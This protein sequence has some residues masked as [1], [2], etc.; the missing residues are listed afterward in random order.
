MA[1]TGVIEQP[2]ALETRSEV[3]KLVSAAVAVRRGASDQVEIGRTASSDT[4]AGRETQGVGGQ[5]VEHAHSQLTRAERL[6]TRIDGKLSSHGHSDTTLLGGAMAETYAGAMLVLAGMSDDLVAGGGLRLSASADLHLAGLIGGEERIGTAIADGALLEAYG[7]HFEREYG[8]GHHVAGFAR[9]SGTIHT[10]VATGFRP[11]FKVM[12]GVRNLTPGTG[13]SGT[14]DANGGTAQMPTPVPPPAGGASPSAGLLGDTPDVARAADA[15]AE[16]LTNVQAI[17]NVGDLATDGARGADTADQLGEARHMTLADIDTALAHQRARA[18]LPDEAGM[19][20]MLDFLRRLGDGE[21]GDEAVRN[22]GEVMARE[23]KDTTSP[24]YDLL[25]SSGLDFDALTLQDTR[26][27]L[28]NEAALARDSGDLARAAELQGILNGFDATV[29]QSTVDFLERFP[30]LPDAGRLRDLPTPLPPAL[31][32][33]P[34]ASRLGAGLDATDVALQLE[35]VR[36]TWLEDFV[37]LDPLLDDD[38]AG[39]AIRQRNNITQAQADLVDLALDEVRRGNDPM[40]ALDAQVQQARLRETNGAARF[41]GEADALAEAA[42]VVRLITDDTATTRMLEGSDVNDLLR[43]LDERTYRTRIAADWDPHRW[44]SQAGDE[45]ESVNEQFRRLLEQ[46]LSPEEAAA[47]NYRDSTSV[48]NALLSAQASATDRDELV[49]LTET[50]RN[51]DNLV[52]RVVNDT[53]TSVD[54]AAGRTTDW[55]WLVD[56]DALAGALRGESQRHLDAIDSAGGSSGEAAAILA[57]QDYLNVYEQAIRDIQRGQ[58]PLGYMDEERRFLE[59]HVRAAEAAASKAEALA[60]DPGSA[61]DEVRQAVAQAAKHRT[62]AATQQARVD[63]LLD[64]RNMVYR[65]M[66]TYAIEDVGGSHSAF[67]ALDGRAVAPN[68]AMPLGYEFA[69]DEAWEASLR[70]GQGNDGGAAGAAN[71]ATSQFEG[72]SIEGAGSL[73]DLSVDES[74]RIDATASYTSGYEVDGGVTWGDDLD[75]PSGY[76]TDGGTWGSGRLDGYETD[77]GTG[78]SGWLDGYETDGSGASPYIL[79][80]MTLPS[81]VDAHGLRQ[82]IRDARQ[83]VPDVDQA[84]RRALSVAV[85]AASRGEDPTAVL[86]DA[87]EAAK[88][89]RNT[90]PLLGYDQVDVLTDVNAL[91]NRLVDQN[92]NAAPALT[93]FSQ[94]D[95]ARRV[96]ALREE[97]DGYATIGPRSEPL[98]TLPRTRQ[99]FVDGPPGQAGLEVG[100]TRHDYD[101]IPG[102]ADVPIHIR[103][104]EIDAPKHTYATVRERRWNKPIQRADPRR[105]GPPPILTIK[106]DDFSRFAGFLRTADGSDDPLNN[107]PLIR[108]TQAEKMAIDDGD[109]VVQVIDTSTFQQYGDFRLV[110]NRPDGIDGGVSRRLSPQDLMRAVASDH[111][112]YFKR[113]ATLA[114]RLWGAMPVP[115]TARFR[116]VSLGPDGVFRPIDLLPP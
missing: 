65:A 47:I 57:N 104:G 74:I 26:T 24:V 96:E 112:N 42:D 76:E 54:E 110:A 45:L 56:Q 88:A 14:A 13:A 107:M 115:P 30:D 99:D 71:V 105:K 46:R 63:R 43:A 64:A 81:D 91:L 80:R 106:D 41:P 11:L 27:L 38:L 97:T 22:A 15:A 95:E 109:I 85:E 17:E 40:A 5:L 73:D 9:F 18:G 8:N 48:R 34:R 111:E 86:N 93:E 29:Y 25:R 60:A 51:Y 12:T 35:D 113:R 59:Y 10:T 6:E 4:V 20:D 98:G 50:I 33:T 114:R 103:D 21:V 90:D 82:A 75:S 49:H 78:S 83:A 77:D 72:A 36:N 100:V 102:Y 70:A 69:G 66:Q 19:E 37:P 28:A 39:D 84:R 44:L 87:I 67:G 101:E 31:T 16:P 116:P 89:R 68:D 1:E 3:L 79:P 23:L 32:E 52:R 62:K 92:R 108:V 55:P 7:T 53:F 61:A 94:V 2:Y 58:N